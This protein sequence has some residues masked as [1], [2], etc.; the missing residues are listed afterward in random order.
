VIGTTT[1]KQ[2]SDD[3]II[4]KKGTL[5]GTIK[6]V[7]NA[8]GNIEFNLGKYTMKGNG[9]FADKECVAAVLSIDDVS[10]TYIGNDGYMNGRKR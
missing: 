8:L 2:P 4:G 6:M 5:G 1:A 3:A 10:E 7:S 9:S